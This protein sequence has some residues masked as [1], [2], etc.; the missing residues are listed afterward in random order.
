MLML[1]LIFVILIGAYSARNLVSLLSQLP[2]SNEDFQCFI[3]DEAYGRY[4]SV[5]ADKRTACAATPAAHAA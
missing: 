1:L 5:A 2:R 3:L 4:L